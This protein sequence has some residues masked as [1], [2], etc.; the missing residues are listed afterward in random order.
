MTEEL[1]ISYKNLFA[2]RPKEKDLNQPSLLADMC[3][4]AGLILRI[5]IFFFFAAGSNTSAPSKIDALLFATWWPE[6]DGCT[7]NLKI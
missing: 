5:F 4:L 3:T 2:Y 1:A 7:L 6:R